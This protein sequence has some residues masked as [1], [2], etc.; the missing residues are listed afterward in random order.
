M[1]IGSR[2]SYHD[3]VLDTTKMSELQEICTKHGVYFLVGIN[4]RMGGTICVPKEPN[5]YRCQGVVAVLETTSA[6]W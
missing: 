2:L 6:S 1:T 5:M 3:D 4:L